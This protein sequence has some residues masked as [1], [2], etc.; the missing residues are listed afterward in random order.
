MSCLRRRGLISRCV[1]YLLASCFWHNDSMESLPCHPQDTPSTPFKILDSVSWRRCGRGG[2]LLGQPGDAARPD[3]L[4]DLSLALLPARM[5][6]ELGSAGLLA[7]ESRSKSCSAERAKRH[8]CRIRRATH[9]RLSQS[10][11]DQ[12]VFPHHSHCDTSSPNHLAG[13]G[14]IARHTDLTLACGFVM[15]PYLDAYYQGRSRC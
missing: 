7:L 14:G 12:S 2:R 8:Y 6:D 15:H 4:H 9:H 5:D 1:I 13:R 3:S 10:P 11:D